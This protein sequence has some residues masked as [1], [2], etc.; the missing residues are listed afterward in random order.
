MN[1]PFA[2]RD[3]AAPDLEAMRA[4]L[5]REI[6]ESTAT[7]TDEERD[8]AA[9]RAW[10]EARLAD[11]HATLVA[12]GGGLLGYATYG[13]FRTWPGY[14]IT[15]ESSV[16]VAPGAQRRGVGRALLDALAARAR[17]GGLVSLVAVIGADRDAS[18]AVHEACGYVERGRLPEV[19]EK[20]GRRLDMV[21]MQRRL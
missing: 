19:G 20:F 18:I 8:A 6:R 15:A 4:L 13:R 16:Y 14:R 21:L 3:A 5:N 1:Q 9:M 10:W 11:G 17:E 2:I 12:E 7:W